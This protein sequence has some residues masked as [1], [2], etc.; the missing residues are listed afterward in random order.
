MRCPAES[1]KTLRI[2]AGLLIFLLPFTLMCLLVTTFKITALYI[3]APAFLGYAACVGAAVWYAKTQQIVAERKD[4]AQEI[5]AI[6]LCAVPL[7]ALFVTSLLLT[8]VPYTLPMSGVVLA[9]LGAVSD[10]S[11]NIWARSPPPATKFSVRYRRSDV[12]RC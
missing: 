12:P 4:R 8:L 3:G 2:I 11:I 9:R 1:E 7:T 5:T 6:V 10:S